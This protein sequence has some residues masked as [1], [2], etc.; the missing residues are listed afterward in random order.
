MT[1]RSAWIDVAEL[2]ISLDRLEDVDPFALSH[3]LQIRLRAMQ[4]ESLASDIAVDRISLP[5][6]AA[7]PGEGS[8]ILSRRIVD[9]VESALAGHLADPSEEA[10]S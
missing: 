4:L 3:Q 2:S 9:A 5:P 7:R 1:A 6:I 10:G 8:A